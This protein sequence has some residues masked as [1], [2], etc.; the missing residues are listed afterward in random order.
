[1]EI[2]EIHFLET[3]WKCIKQSCWINLSAKNKKQQLISI[4]RDPKSQGTSKS[5]L[6]FIPR[7]GPGGKSA[8]PPKKKQ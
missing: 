6:L 2:G 3:A 7:C 5:T 8:P 4:Q 1:M